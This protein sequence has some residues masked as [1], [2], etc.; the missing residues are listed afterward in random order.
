MAGSATLIGHLPNSDGPLTHSIPVTA[1]TVNVIGML[2]VT[3][4]PSITPSALST[5]LKGVYGTFG[6]VSATSV[7]M[8]M[9][10]L[11]TLA[12]GSASASVAD[13]P[14]GTG[15]VP[16]NSTGNRAVIAVTVWREKDT[17]A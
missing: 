8:S 15:C 16:I 3:I 14:T 7:V 13:R 5:I 4:D 6:L 10:T 12:A 17:D 9:V 11:V 2:S 1:P